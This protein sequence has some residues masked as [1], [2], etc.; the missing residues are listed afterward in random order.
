MMKPTEFLSKLDH[1]KVVAAVRAAEQKTS[2]EIRVFISRHSPEDPIAEAQRDFD[3]LGMGKTKEKNGVLIFV[4][5][6]ARKFAVIG[7]SG[8]HA[9][10]GNAFW[11]ALA[12]E[13]TG[14]FKAGAFTEGIIHA[15]TKAGE[16]L[17]EHFP[18]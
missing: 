8:V 17:A 3:K 2:G 6:R 5:P 16:L 11:Q 7:D 18:R 10:C 4:A 13:M 15:V 12:S 9:K 14:H 1:D